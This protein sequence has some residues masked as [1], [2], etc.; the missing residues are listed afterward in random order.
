MSVSDVRASLLL[1]LLVLAAYYLI[2]GIW[3]NPEDYDS[4]AGT[5]YYDDMS[6]YRD[7]LYAP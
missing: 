2:D 6:S 3:L 4:S 5:D 1:I 7:D